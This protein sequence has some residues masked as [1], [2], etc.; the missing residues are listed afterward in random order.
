MPSQARSSGGGGA[1]V[2]PDERGDV[3]LSHGS[4]AMSLFESSG[5]IV[6]VNDAWVS[7]Y[8]YTREEAKRMSVA[9]VSAEPDETR[10][11]LTHAMT[12]GGVR[13]DARWHKRKDGS[14][15]PVDVTSG[16]VQLGDRQL[17][18]A[19]MN[20]ISERIRGTDAL[21][22]SEARFR[23]LIESMPEAVLVHREGRI[24]YVN[25]AART[26][27]GYA[28]TAALVGTPA[29]DVVHPE[30]RA[31]A[32]ERI[33]AA[34]EEG[35][36]APAVESR[37]L[38]ADGSIVVLEVASIPTTFDGDAVILVI[39]RDVTARRE[40][41]AKLLMA[42]R[43]AA[44]GRLA[45]S[46]GHEINNPLTYVLGNVELLRRKLVVAG[47]AV[48][49]DLRTS[50]VQSL[51]L[52][53][54]GAERVRDIV[55][56]LRTLSRGEPDA[57]APV[58]VR[59][60]VDVCASMAEHEL[61]HRARLVLDYAGDGQVL[62]SEA[63]LGQVFLNLLVNAAQAIPEGN[64]DANE[65]RVTVT[66]PT[67]ATIAVEVRD[68]GSGIAHLNADRLFEPFFTTKASGGGT[69]LGLSICDHIVR[70][71]GGTISAS[72]V[73]P[74]G[75]CFRVVLPA[76]E[77]D[78]DAPA[79]PSRARVSMAPSSARVMVVDDEP[80]VAKVIAQMLDGCDVE[81][82]PSGR[83]ALERIARSPKFDAVFCDV[84]MGDL[85]GLDVY[86]QVR[87]QDERLAGR[88]V[89]VTGGGLDEGTRAALEATGRPCVEKPFGP[90]TLRDALE[91][92]LRER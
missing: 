33:R 23:A 51:D 34:V 16:I 8:G 65:V 62:A 11:A 35:R 30:D 64:V 54:S 26:I 71:L 18:Y 41:E 14:V 75:T 59:R 46:V 78:D 72:H 48:D 67:L 36:V 47:G 10:S 83:D 21:Q 40:M 90:G 66:R 4:S 32:R 92:V 77:D 61:R 69:G 60:V 38:R 42:D 20:D 13:V 22:R 82:A 12:A 44:L 63:R 73:A 56:D 80:L 49:D 6:D 88:F 25:P 17:L 43:L 24:V 89:F 29:L 91:L 70:S 79:P 52:I 1:V 3:A 37:T 76:C 74:H 57:S 86:E 81:I 85:T 9:D 27:L 5:Q 15:F 53:E 31:Q 50:L 2:F 7:F 58:D 19:V 87:K 55:R 68:T 45:A 39:G 28:D 84:R